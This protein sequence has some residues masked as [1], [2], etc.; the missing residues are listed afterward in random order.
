MVAIVVTSDRLVLQKLTRRFKAKGD[1]LLLHHDQIA[2]ARIGGGGGMGADPS[3][4]VLDQVG[5]MLVIETTGGERLKLRMMDGGKLGG[6][7]IQE[8]GVRALGEWL[9]RAPSG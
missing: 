3:A 8:E 4:L 9:G 1:P 6:G 5:T 2:E 7:S